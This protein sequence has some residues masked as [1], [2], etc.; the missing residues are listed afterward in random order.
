MAAAGWMRSGLAL[1]LALIFTAMPLPEG[2]AIARP[3]MVPLVLCW[4]CLHVPERFGVVWAFALGLILDVAHSTSLGQHAL[5]LTLLIYLLS[6]LRPTLL[7]LPAWQQT[8]VLIP[9]WLGYQGLL[10]WLDGFVQQS[11]DPLWRWL[12]VISTSLCWLP[13]CAVLAASDRPQHQSV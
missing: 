9:L 6:K 13:L 2:M 5:A 8:L 3:A 11:I 1:L 10:L 12:P 7:L 4:L